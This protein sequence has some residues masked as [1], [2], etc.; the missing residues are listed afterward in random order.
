[1][2]RLLP[3]QKFRIFEKESQSVQSESSLSVGSKIVNFLRKFGYTYDSGKDSKIFVS[4]KT[5]NYKTIVPPKE[6]NLGGGHYSSPNGLYC[7]DMNYFKERLFGDDE[8]NPNNFNY[9]NLEAASNLI[10]NLCLGFENEREVPPDQKWREGI[11]RWLWIVKMKDDSLIIS[12]YTSEKVLSEKLITLL[13]NYSHYFL[14]SSNVTNFN[15]QDKKPIVQNLTNLESLKKFFSENANNY[16]PEFIGGMS[17]TKTDS[18]MRTEMPGVNQIFEQYTNHVEL[19]YFIKLCSE[20]IGGKSV[21][22]VM[23]EIC[24]AIGIDGFTQRGESHLHPRP[25]NQTVLLNDEGVQSMIRI[26]LKEELGGSAQKSGDRYSKAQI[27]DFKKNKD[28]FLSQLKIGDIVYNQKTQTFVRITKGI[29]ATGISNFGSHSSDYLIPSQIK[30]INLDESE[31]WD[32]IKKLKDGDRI[33]IEI[34]D[35]SPSQIFKN[36]KSMKDYKKISWDCELKINSI[37][38]ETWEVDVDESLANDPQ[39]RKI[40]SLTSI[41]EIIFEFKNGYGERLWGFRSFVKTKMKMSL[42]RGDSKEPIKTILS[43]WEVQ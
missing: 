30:K 36:S 27:E 16:K 19:Y 18:G 31:G 40:E 25:K 35:D 33:E 15:P 39:T 32:F 29:L 9:E 14:K 38:T 20:L 26:D 22:S 23:T 24:Q 28:E 41:L 8:I 13:N 2:K 3:Y 37:N 21:F 5:G 4:F 12:S 17:S 1:M 11:P 42:F 43:P 10:D 34:L 6:L 7:W